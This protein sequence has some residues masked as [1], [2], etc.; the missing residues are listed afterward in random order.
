MDFREAGTTGDP[1]VTISAALAGQQFPIPFEV[2]FVPAQIDPA[3]SYVVGARILLGDQVLYASAVGVP[4]I[5]QGAPTT[6]VTV[7]IPP[8]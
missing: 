3:K 2:P 7:N 5:T 4:V 1:I 6:D 8:Q